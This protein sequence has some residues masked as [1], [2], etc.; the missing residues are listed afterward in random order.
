MIKFKVEEIVKLQGLWISFL[1][2][3]DTYTSGHAVLFKLQVSQPLTS[4]AH[5]V[6]CKEI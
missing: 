2:G 6:C 5:S 3:C 4:S 1:W